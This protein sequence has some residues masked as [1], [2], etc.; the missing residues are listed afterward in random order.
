MALETDLRGYLARLEKDRQDDVIHLSRQVPRD[1]FLSSFIFQLEKRKKYP[2]VIAEHLEKSTMPVVA[3]LFAS[4]ERFAHM[5]NIPSSELSSFWKRAQSSPIP[6][7]RV[8][9]GPVQEI[10]YEKDDIDVGMFPIS[11][12]L[13]EDAGRYVSSGIILAKDP[14]TGVSN[15]SYHRMQLKSRNKFGI[16][17]HSRGHL[18]DFF[19]RAEERHEALEVAVII[20]AHPA[21]YLAAGTKLPNQMSEMDLAGALMG[22]PIDTVR[23]K[24][25]SLDIPAGA[26]IIFEGRIVPDEREKEG[27]FGE[28]TG[29][30]TFRS[31]DNVLVIDFV[32]HRKSPIFLDLIPGPSTEHLFLGGIGKES[33]VIERLKEQHDVVKDVNYPKSGTH[34][35]AYISMKKQAEGQAKLAILSLFGLDSYLKMIVAVDEDVDIYNEEEVLWALATRVKADKDVFIIPDVMCNKLDPSS[36]DGL[37]SKM[38]IDATAPLDWDVFR[39]ETNGEMDVLSETLLKELGY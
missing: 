32:M 10:C 18:W 26:E 28:Y 12:H 7:Q 17:L 22:E 3:N 30:S 1:Y 14:D 36:V 19:R 8:E 29:Y 25:T 9:T 37:Q 34:F 39:C 2:V 15:L 38:G 31:T 33:I 13:A 11:T 35:H 6:P 20:G 23:G 21:L 16:S 4:R 24:T 5:L 27:P